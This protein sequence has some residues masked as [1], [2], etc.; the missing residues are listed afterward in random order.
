MTWALAVQ[1]SATPP[2]KQKSLVSDKPHQDLSN[3]DFE[4]LLHR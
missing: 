2:A 3:G 1:L 4:R